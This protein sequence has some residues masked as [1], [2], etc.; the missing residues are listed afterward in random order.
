MAMPQQV[1]IVEVGPARRSAERAGSPCRRQTKLELIERLVGAG[2]K[3]IEAAAFVSPKWVPQMADA[4]EVM[5]RLAAVPGVTYTALT[6]NLK[7]FEAAL[8]AG[9]EE[10]AVFAAA[11]EAFS[12]KNINC[13]IAESIARFR[14]VVAAAARA[15]HPR[16]RLHLLRARL[17]LLGR[18]SAGQQSPPWRPGSTISGCYEISLGDTI[19]A[20]TPGK[21]WR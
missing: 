7:G 19:G 18:S 11:S 14:P 6:P 4:G 5:R 9:C 12:Q 20:G 3:T 10:V 16:P 1:R 21:T 8:A 13:S 15:K 17:P 2:L